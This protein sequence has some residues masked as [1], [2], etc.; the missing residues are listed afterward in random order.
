M[1]KHNLLGKKGEDIATQ[2][3][4]DKG[5]TVLH[6]NWRAGKK[7]LDIIAQ[8]TAGTIAIVEVKTRRNTVFG[9]PETA[10]TPQKMHHLI[11]ATEDFLEQTQ[12][13]APIRFDIITV[14]G[15][16]P[17]FEITHIEDAF[18]SPIWN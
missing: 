12:S 17:P 14:V 7:D 4:V 16:N 2:Y 5:Y 6:R 3:L 13:D 11:E 18:I 9:T 15:E 8:D 1:A 10:V